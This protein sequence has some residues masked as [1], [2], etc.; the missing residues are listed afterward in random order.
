MII[1]FHIISIFLVYLKQWNIITNKIKDIKISLINLKKQNDNQNNETTK[2]G[3]NINK[4]KNEV[5]N[6]IK[7]K[8]EKSIGKYEQN[9]LDVD[10]I[11]KKKKKK[12]K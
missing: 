1:I 2:I 8:K 3:N 9:I 10:E 11:K 12:K 6:N 5:N 7:I 4:D